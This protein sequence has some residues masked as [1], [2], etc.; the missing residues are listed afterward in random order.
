MLDSFSLYIVQRNYVFAKVS[1][2]NVIK[3]D[4]ARKH[5][6]LQVKVS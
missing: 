1:S 4:H 5:G 6:Q 3:K 2:I